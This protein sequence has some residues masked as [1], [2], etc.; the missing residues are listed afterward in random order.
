MTRVTLRSMQRPTDRGHADGVGFG[1]VVGL[2][3]PDACAIGRR[4]ATKT[5]ATTTTAN[6]IAMR[7]VD[8]RRESIR[9]RMSRGFHQPSDA[10]RGRNRCP[11]SLRF[12]AA[13]PGDSKGFK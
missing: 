9:P 6:T 4:L 11:R 8:R 12:F 1:V 13:N 7:I 2:L 10:L 5:A 3:P